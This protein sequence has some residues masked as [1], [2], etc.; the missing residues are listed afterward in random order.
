MKQDDT[1]ARF[2]E[3]LLTAYFSGTATAE[4]E[5][6]LLAWIRSSDDNRRTFAELRAVWQRGRMQRPDTQLQAR[7]VRSLNSLINFAATMLMSAG[8]VVFRCAALQ[9]RQSSP[10]RSPR[11]S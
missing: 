4:E 5:Q 8:A 6:A 11:L 3:Q 1:T 10:W 7:F 2:D 9:R